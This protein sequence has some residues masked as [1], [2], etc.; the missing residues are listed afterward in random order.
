MEEPLELLP[1][2]LAISASRGEASIASV[3]TSG[4]NIEKVPSIIYRET[5]VC[6]ARNHEEEG[7]SCAVSP[8][9]PHFTFV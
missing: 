5:W 9:F 6:E 4:L 7:E 8:L 3:D 2:V 1:P